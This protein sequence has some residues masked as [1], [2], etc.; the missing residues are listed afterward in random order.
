VITPTRE[1]ALQVSDVAS[2]IGT[3]MGV[4]TITVYGGASI[5]VQIDALRRGVNVVVGTPG[6]LLDLIERGVLDLR[7]I[8]FVVL[9]EGDIMMDMG[10][11]DDIEMILKRTPSTKQ[12]MLFSATMPDK[13]VAIAERYMKPQKARITVGEEEDI[14]ATGIKHFFTIANGSTKFGTLIAYIN[15]YNPRK[16]IVFTMTKRSADLLHRVLKG[17]GFDAVVMHGALTQAKR[18]H[19]LSTFKAGARFLI[20]TNIASRGLD[21]KD[22]TDVINF[23]APD[24]PEVYV[25]RVGRSA[26]MGKEGRAF[27]LFSYEQR[28]MVNVIKRIANVDMDQLH[29]SDN[30]IKAIDIKKYLDSGRGREGGGFRGPRRFGDRGGSRDRPS[31]GHGGGSRFHD[32]NERRPGGFQ[33]R[34]P[35]GSGRP[36]SHGQSF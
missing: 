22:V 17:E 34:R 1:L 19:S 32:R 26:R 15:K 5:N 36:Q 6:R 16:A 10:F 31:H 28:Y 9:D 29:F 25:H 8:K 12:M 4:R 18:E 2:K 3:P 11:I 27:T 30:E 24:E 21:I 20:S 23:D 7:S 13:I 35:G 14:T 33:H